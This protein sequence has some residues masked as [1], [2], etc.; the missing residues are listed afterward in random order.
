MRHKQEIRT[1]Q[2]YSKWSLFE[3]VVKE[4]YASIIFGIAHRSSL[5]LNANGACP[6]IMLWNK[7][8]PALRPSQGSVM[9]WML[10]F[11]QT[12]VQSLMSPLHTIFHFIVMNYMCNRPLFRA[13]SSGYEDARTC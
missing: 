4:I 5:H 3:N 7:S 6:R 10:P 2:V 12:F 8:R 11:R 9:L 1:S 13:S